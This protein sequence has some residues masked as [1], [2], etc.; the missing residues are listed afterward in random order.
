[1]ITKALYAADPYLTECESTVV[2][3]TNGIVLSETVFYPLG[4]GQAGDTG[5]LVM[6]TGEEVLIADTRFVDGADHSKGIAHVPA[7]GQEGLL[8]RLKA[9]DVVHAHIDWTRRLQHMRLHTASHLAG[10]ILSIETDGCSVTRE[11]ARLDFVTAE[12]ISADQL[13]EALAKIVAD[14]RDVTC[15]LIAVDELAQHATAAAWAE[16]VPDG[17]DVLRLVNIAGVDLQP[18]AGTH[19]RNTREI[20]SVRVKKVEKKSSRTRRVTLEL[21]D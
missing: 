5:K 13:Q 18:C 1:M 9:G 17:Q 19:V 8:S 6:Q 14:E 4:G 16:Q 7:E 10:A 2:D 21:V 15:E 12:P 3:V 20:G 11:R